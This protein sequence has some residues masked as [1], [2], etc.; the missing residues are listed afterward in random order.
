VPP[1]AADDDDVL[2]G[3]FT[4]FAKVWFKMHK[5]YIGGVAPKKVHPQLDFVHLYAACLLYYQWM[6]NLNLKACVRFAELPV[7]TDEAM[8][9]CLN[10]QK[11]QLILFLQKL[12]YF[13][14]FLK[15]GKSPGA[16]LETYTFGMCLINFR[17]KIKSHR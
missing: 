1:L 3:V 13:C 15:P 10:T 2:L 11:A 14:P 5:C 16:F 17:Q 8:L 9:V 7:F 4:N 6:C 12:Y